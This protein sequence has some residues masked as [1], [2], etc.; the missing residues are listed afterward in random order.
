MHAAGKDYVA[1]SAAARDRRN[2]LA[3]TA[4]GVAAGVA[5]VPMAL[6]LPSG[7]LFGSIRSGDARRLLQK[8]VAP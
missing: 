3:L 2:D 7:V 6:R 4:I 5:L 8:P 1:I